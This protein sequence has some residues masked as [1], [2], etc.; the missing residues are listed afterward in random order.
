MK[1]AQQ[2]PPHVGLNPRP[3]T[4]WLAPFVLGVLR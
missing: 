2:W 1:A 4:V 3:P